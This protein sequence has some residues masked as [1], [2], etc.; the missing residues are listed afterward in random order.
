MISPLRPDPDVADLAREFVLRKWR[1][2]AAERGLSV[3]R[4]LSGS[5]KFS[6][7][8]ASRLFGLEM[9]GNEDHQFCIH[10]DGSIFD[11][12]ADAEDVRALANP[13]KHDPAFWMNPDHQES[14]ESCHPRVEAWLDEFEKDYRAGVRVHI[15]APTADGGL[16]AVSIHGDGEGE[17][18][19]T[20]I[21][22]TGPGEPRE[23]AL[24]AAEACGWALTDLEDQPF[25]SDK[26]LDGHDL[27]FRA[28][29]AI[30][31]PDPDRPDADSG[32]AHTRAALPPTAPELDPHRVAINLWR[33]LVAAQDRLPD[34]FVPKQQ[35]PSINFLFHDFAE[36]NPG[37]DF[38]RPQ[39]DLQPWLVQCEIGDAKISL[40]PHTGKAA[41]E[42]EALYI[43][44]EELQALVDRLQGQN[45]ESEPEDE[46]PEMAM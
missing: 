28:A 32:P 42:G 44:S 16:A 8:F 5:C 3:P 38:Y 1:E 10:P 20:L 24:A 40:W 46:T 27:W 31:L 11:L 39:P 9:R 35:D 34:L 12:N 43:G 18:V 25:M 23:V 17:S 41:A 4:D 19:R 36:E 2:R 37:L 6:S 22:G 21:G 15:I 13:W 26:S 7:L 33:G 14:M 30:P 45:A 29:R